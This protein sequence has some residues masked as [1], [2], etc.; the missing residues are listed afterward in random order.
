[1]L[2]KIG[3]LLI[4][5]SISSLA[6]AV[7]GFFAN[8]PAANNVPTYTYKIIKVYPHDPQAFTEG[9]AFFNCSIY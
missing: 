1:M 4:L 9:L 3:A 8:A 2:S 6:I 7:V 5:I